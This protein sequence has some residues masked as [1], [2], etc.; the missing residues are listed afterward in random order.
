MQ[1]SLWFLAVA[2]DE[3]LICSRQRER[4]TLKYNLQIVR[5]TETHIPKE[6]ISAFTAAYHSK[7][8]R[9]KIYYRGIQGLSPIIALVIEELLNPRFKRLNHN[10]I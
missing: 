4:D 6:K 10:L 1:V 9:Y 2:F 8:R 5:I 3:Q 7:K